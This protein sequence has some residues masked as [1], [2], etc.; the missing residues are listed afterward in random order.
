M[1]LT[2]TVIRNAKYQGKQIKLSDEKGMYLLVNQAGKYFR[3][4]YRFADKRKT[5]ALGVYPET[6]LKE[7][8]EKRD[9]ARKMITNG[10]NPSEVR[11]LNR[12]SLIDDTENNFESIASEWYIKY[13]SKWTPQHA[14]RK[15]RALEKDVFPYIGKM[16]LKNITPLDI[17]RVLNRI[18]DRGA[19]ETAHRAKSICSEVFRYG[20]L[21]NRCERDFTQDLKGA[22]LPTKVKNMACITNTNRLSG[23]LKAIDSYEGEFITRCA[24]QLA[25][26]VF[27]RPGELRHAE[28]SEIDFDKKEWRIP[29]EKMKMRRIHIVPLSEQAIA[30]LKEIEPITGRWKY[31]FPSVRSKDRPMS[32]NTMNAAL[33]RMGFTKEEMTSHG[34]R[35]VASTLLHENGFNS[36]YIETQLAHSESNKVKAAYNHAEYLKERTEMMNWWANFL[37]EVKV[38]K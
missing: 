23:L 11:K 8:R 16:P 18:Q 1:A 3:L 13:K 17:L 33:R 21:N 36:L 4:D 15:W 10:I 37:D 19:I 34:F 26:L 30:I 25:P 7:A 20:V 22:L 5:L 24:L 28:W 27:V 29:A 12:Q 14:E 2:D 35:G 6:S 32:N 31:V 9:Q 38:D